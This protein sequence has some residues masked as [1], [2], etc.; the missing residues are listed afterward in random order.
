MGKPWWVVTVGFVVLL[1]PIYHAFVI[2]V[3]AAR[4]EGRTFSIRDVPMEMFGDLVAGELIVNAAVVA[5]SVLFLLP[6]I[7]IGLR[8][9]YYK[10]AIILHKARSLS[11]V[12][13]SFALTVLPRDT[14]WM[15]LLLAGAYSVPLATDFLL[16]PET[17]TL[18]IHAVAILVSATFLAWVNAYVTAS[19]MDI[20]K[21]VSESQQ[22]ASPV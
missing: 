9:I 12:R 17:P 22:T 11:G 5:G 20:T 6:G 4:F 3:A 7:Y 15:L 16:M 8:S 14:L 19:F 10:Q 13:E 2:Q 1:S 18:W 21:R